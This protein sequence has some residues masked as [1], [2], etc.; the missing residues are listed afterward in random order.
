MKIVYLNYMWDLW[1][2]SIGSTIKAL[3]VLRALESCGHEI[4]KYW[5][6]DDFE[7]KNGGSPRESTHGLYVFMKKYFKR[8]LHEPSQLYKNFSLIKQ[9]LAI[10]EEEKPDLVI[11]RIDS[12]NFSNA[13]VA[14]RTNLP[15]LIEADCPASYEKIVFQK[16]FRSTKWLLYHLERKQIMTGRAAFTV[17]NL[18]KEYFV[19]HGVPDDFMHVIPNGADP[20]R[21]KP[22]VD[23]AAVQKKYNLEGCTVVGFVGSFIYWHGIENLTYVMEKTLEGDKSTKFLMVGDGGPMKPMLEKFIT[24]KKLQNRAILTG[25]V[26]HEEIP[27]YIAA[28]DVVL[29]PYPKLDFFYY[30]PVKIYEYMCVGKPV[31]STRIGQIAEVIADQKNG[32]LTEPDD[33]EQ[34]KKTIIRL[35]KNADL[36]QEVGQAARDAILAK[37]TWKKR[38]EQL[39]QLCYQCVQ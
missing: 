4:K 24:E 7:R 11:S 15:F 2:I 38:G 3:E 30:S 14:Q 16:Y 37:H 39:S 9:E 1:G 28:M 10:L 5:L 29:A 12:Y 35:L 18:M 33:V 27:Q 23:K 8:Y 22:N 21:F 31:V 6:N 19:N 20:D 32:F 26:P 25:F 34:I 17:S 13:K 36:R